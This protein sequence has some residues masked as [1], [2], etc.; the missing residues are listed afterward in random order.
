MRTIKRTEHDIYP[1]ISATGRLAN[2]AKGKSV[3]ITG[4]GKGIG[5]VCV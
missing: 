1:Y 5:R 4:G 3:L 2:A